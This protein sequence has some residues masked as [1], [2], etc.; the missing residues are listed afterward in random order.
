MMAWTLNHM[1]ALFL[2]LWIALAPALVA[3]PAAGLTSQMSMV[4][5]LASD[6]CDC[7][8]DAQ[9]N[10][11]LC[12]SMCVNVLPFATLQFDHLVSITFHDAYALRRE[13]TPS[14][15]TISPDPPPPRSIAF[16]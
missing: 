3:A 16:R 1:L 11:E 10:R 13:L 15:R 7:C 6:K 8:S 9:P 4:H 12:A 14:S 5:V 2:G